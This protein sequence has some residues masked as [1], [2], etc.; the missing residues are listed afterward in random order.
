M[1]VGT[2]E[3]SVRQIKE[4]LNMKYDQE[5]NISLSLFISDLNQ[6]FKEL[7][8]LKEKVAIF[9]KFNYL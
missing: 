3:E 2:D 8:S 7:E 4:N 6:R 1:N 9:D 5:E